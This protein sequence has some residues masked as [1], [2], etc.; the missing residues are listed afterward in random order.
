[1]YNWNYIRKVSFYHVYPILWLSLIFFYVY[2]WIYILTT[3]HEHADIYMYHVYTCMYHMCMWPQLTSQSQA[4]IW[5][6]IRRQFLF[7]VSLSLNMLN[8]LNIHKYHVLYNPNC[9]VKIHTMIV[10]FIDKQVIIIMI[11]I[12]LSSYQKKPF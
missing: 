7:Q 12:L 9:G 5:P 4:I 1:M 6:R 11:I 8:M 2:T 3:V 10:I